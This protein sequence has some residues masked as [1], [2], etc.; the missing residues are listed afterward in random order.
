MVDSQN[1]DPNIC[2]L[3][4]HSDTSNFILFGCEQLISIAEGRIS[5]IPRIPSF[6]IQTLCQSPGPN[7]SAPKRATEPQMFT[8]REMLPL[9]LQH[10]LMGDFIFFTSQPQDLGYPNL[11]WFP[12]TNEMYV[13]LYLHSSAWHHCQR[14]AVSFVGI[15]GD[16]HVNTV[17]PV[18]GWFSKYTQIK[19]LP[20]ELAHVCGSRA[21]A[22]GVGRL[23]CC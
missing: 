13:Y 8:S 14:C 18:K 11:N 1:L 16:T 23:H 21:S 6:L 2:I 20:D 10:Y 7:T 22:L 19:L 3:W 15:R 12:E 4:I 5:R 17:K 9:R